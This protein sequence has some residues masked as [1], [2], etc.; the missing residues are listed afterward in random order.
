MVNG[1]EETVQRRIQ[2]PHVV[3]GQNIVEIKELLHY[4]RK[5][6]SAQASQSQHPFN[7]AGNAAPGPP[8]RPWADAAD[9]QQHQHPDRARTQQIPA[10]R[11]APDPR[12]DPRAQLLG[13]GVDPATGRVVD[14]YAV[15]R[16][17][18]EPV[19]RV[20]FEEHEVAE[21]ATGVSIDSAF[22]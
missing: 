2:V 18:A 21:C 9:S 10:P 5:S 19:Q 11:H 17:V 16:R 4:E 12:Q 1:K 3:Q 20:H 8:D 22:L 13:T 15:V 7:A 14:Q 6:S